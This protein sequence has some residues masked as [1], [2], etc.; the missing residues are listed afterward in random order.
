[1]G[2]L[3]PGDTIARFGGDEFVTICDD[4]A[5]PAEAEIIARRLLG[6]LAVPFVLDGGDHVVSGSIGIAVAEA[7]RRN[8]EDLIREADAAMYRAKERGRNRYE[9]YDEVMR[10]RA[11]ARLRIEG[12]LRRALNQGEL[13][14]HYQPIVATNTRQVHGV[15]ALVR[16]EHPTRGLLP[17]AEF[18]PVA[19]DTGVI[20][21]LGEWVLE[22][23]CRQA[24]AWHCS[25][26]DLPPALMA[27]NLSSR[28]IAHP[29]IVDHVRRAVAQSGMDVTAL[30]LE[31]TES[32]LMEDPVASAETLRALKQ[33]GVT[34]VLD[35]FG[36]GY[37]SLAYLRQFPIDVLKIDRR[38][39]SDLHAAD[40]DATIVR[41]VLHMAAGLGIEVIAEGVENA[42]THDRLKDLGCRLA[43]GYHYARPAPATEAEAL[44]ELRLPAVVETAVSPSRRARA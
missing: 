31:I 25:R 11:L 22:E 6:A 40:A 41:A 43:Q 3:R 10:A 36:T 24:A 8:P 37:S 20:V 42:A 2:N 18:V 29:A 28:Q 32:V 12:E 5:D 35:D 1:M 19:E 13:R 34:L 9:L 27:V 23:A 7:T 26:P 15:E 21:P 16:W 30:H 14:L 39:V 38:F 33:L 4:L 44:L 17:P